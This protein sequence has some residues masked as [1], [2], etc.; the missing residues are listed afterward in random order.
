MNCNRCGTQL[1]NGETVCRQCGNNMGVSQNQNVNPNYQNQPNQNMNY[2]VPSNKN[3]KII[4]IVVVILAVLF[5][6]GRV[7][8]AFVNND[9]NNNINDILNG[10]NEKDK[11]IDEVDEDDLE[12]DLDTDTNNEYTEME[13]FY[14]EKYQYEFVSD[15]YDEWI[16]EE[17]NGAYIF[18]KDNTYKLYLDGDHTDNYCEGKIKLRYGAIYGS[19]GLE[20]TRYT[21]DDGTKI[22]SLVTYP[23]TCKNEGILET[24]DNNENAQIYVLNIK[25]DTIYILRLETDDVFELV[26]K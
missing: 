1:V 15:V 23:N 24:Y 5:I 10:L 8:F 12:I 22:Y 3:N 11:P 14:N 21:D 4:I 25:G 2:N 7:F 26:R 17:S 20:Y 18:N 19:E 13:K 9:I 16:F 6:A